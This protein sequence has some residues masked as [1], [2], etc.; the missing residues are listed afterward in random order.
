MAKVDSISDIVAK[1]NER[2][3][4]SPTPPL[5]SLSGEAET[6]GCLLPSGTLKDAHY[7]YRDDTQWI[8]SNDD[9]AAGVG[10]LPD[11]FVDC[12]VTSPLTI[13]KGTMTWTVR[14]ARKIHLRLTSRP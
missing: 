6:D 10:R 8:L 1:L 13:G 7:G 2:V 9:A 14:P 3:E 5:T 12:V 4:P 11:N